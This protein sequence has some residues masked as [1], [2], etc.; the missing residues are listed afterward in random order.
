MDTYLVR[1]EETLGCGGLGMDFD[2]HIWENLISNVECQMEFWDRRADQ[3]DPTEGAEAWI[4][5]A[6]GLS[7][8][9]RLLSAC[10]PEFREL[11]ACAKRLREITGS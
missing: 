5:K 3:Q 9:L 1:I 8:A 10:E 4:A 7:Y 6:E 2:P 11:V